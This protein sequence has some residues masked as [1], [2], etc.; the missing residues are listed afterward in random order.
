MPKIIAFDIGIHHF[1]HAMIQ[2]EQTHWEIQHMG[3]YDFDPNHKISKINLDQTFLSQFH[4][5]LKGL[6]TWIEK[7]N[8]CLIER[9]VGFAK[10]VNYKCIQLAS[11]L[12]CHILLHFPEKQII[13]YAAFEKTKQFGKQFKKKSDRKK[14][15]VEFTKDMLIQQ[16]D[17]TSLGWMASFPKE[18]DICDCILMIL[19]FSK[20]NNYFFNENEVLHN[21]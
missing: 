20:K 8:Y 5:Y 15:A 16:Q 21:M 11:H 2:V 10:M 12:F 14:C 18:D 13:E 6:H 4:E 17:E 9:Q 1:A 19:S 7:C 3:C